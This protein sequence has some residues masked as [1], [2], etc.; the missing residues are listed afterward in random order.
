MQTI[1]K[2]KTRTKLRTRFHRRHR[3]IRNV[4]PS[5]PSWCREESNAFFEAFNK[6]SC[7][8]SISAVM[9]VFRFRFFFFG[10][11]VFLLSRCCATAVLVSAVATSPAMDADDPRPPLLVCVLVV[12]DSIGCS[13]IRFVLPPSSILVLASASKVFDFAFC[14]FS[15]SFLCNSKF[16]ACDTIF[17]MLRLPLAFFLV[18]TYGVSSFESFSASSPSSSPSSSSNPRRTRVTCSGRI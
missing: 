12:V 9:T 4:T 11:G 14:S 8:A 15:S 10:T 16:R 17:S 7:S 5:P 2:N 18:N 3:T 13:F 6:R 1:S